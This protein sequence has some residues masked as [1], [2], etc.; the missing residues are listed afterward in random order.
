MNVAAIGRQRRS[1]VHGITMRHIQRARLKRMK[2]AT[3]IIAMTEAFSF[4]SD[5]SSSSYGS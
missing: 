4:T 2:S 5:R 3:H 1:T